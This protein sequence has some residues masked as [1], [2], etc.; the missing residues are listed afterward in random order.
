MNTITLRLIR[1]AALAAALV[2]LSAAGY[3]GGFQT[4]AEDPAL[5]AMHLNGWISVER[6]SI[7]RVGSPVKVAF[8]E[9][10][11]A[12]RYL[13]D[14]TW[15]IYKDFY[16]EHSGAHGILVLSSKDGVVTALRLVSPSVAVHLAANRADIFAKVVVASNR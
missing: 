11:P 8:G 15:L 14:G 3:A 9:L 13:S 16:V 1:A 7:V 5:N 10:G 2:S 12:D 6:V 4:P